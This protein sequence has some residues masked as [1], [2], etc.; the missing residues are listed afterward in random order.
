MKGELKMMSI[1]RNCKIKLS[2]ADFQRIKQFWYYKFEL[3]KKVQNMYISHMF[4]EHWHKMS[5]LFLK[6]HTTQYLLRG[7]SM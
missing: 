2:N 5:K 6:V 4:N 3:K 7:C 1:T